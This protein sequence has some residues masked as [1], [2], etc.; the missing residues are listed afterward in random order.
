MFTLG[1]L[2]AR[3]IASHTFILISFLELSNFINIFVGKV[4]LNKK[5]IIS[6]HTNHIM[7]YRNR[8]FYGKTHN[9]LIKLLYPKADKII[10][11]SKKIKNILSTKYN[12]PKE[13]IEV[14]YN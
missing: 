8:S 4:L 1:C 11:V 6:V 2:L 9:I 12:I 13:K 10:V 14:I 7:R 5:V 3:S